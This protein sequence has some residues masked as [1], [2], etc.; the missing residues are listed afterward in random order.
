MYAQDKAAL[1]TDAFATMM[2]VKQ[3]CPLSGTLYGV[4]SDP[5]EKAAAAMDKASNNGAPWLAAGT[6]VPSVSYADDL[7]LLAILEQRLQAMLDA[8]KAFRKENKLT[9]NVRKTNLWYLSL[10]SPKTILCFTM[11]ANQLRRLVC[12]ST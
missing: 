9:V 4:Y 10:A 1:K 2:G 12:S 3:G 5:I 7:V 8:L 6:R 11:M